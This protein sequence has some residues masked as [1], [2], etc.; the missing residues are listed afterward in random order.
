[1]KEIKAYI[2]RDRVA[3]VISALKDSAAWGGEEGDARHNLAAYLVRGLV[4]SP[5]GAERH[6][7]VDLGDEVINEFKLELICPDEEAEELV[8]VISANARTGDAQAGWITV[9]DL[10][11]AAPIR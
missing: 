1:M 6:Y 7:S 4:A 5:V 9:A 2:H 3:D 11:S 8:R 10:V